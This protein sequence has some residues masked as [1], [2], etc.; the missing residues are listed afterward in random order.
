MLQEFRLKSY[1]VS[2]NVAQMRPA[3]GDLMSKIC[4]TWPI[5]VQPGNVGLILDRA[6][7]NTGKEK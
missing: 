2:F 3:I 7:Q 4:K 6:I 1:S 5:F